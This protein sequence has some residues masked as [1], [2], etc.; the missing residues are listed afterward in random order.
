MSTEQARRLLGGYATGT[1]TPDETRALFEAA[2]E[3]Q[4]LF[5]ELNHEQVLRDLLDDGSARRDVL[6]ALSRAD[7]LG[8]PMRRWHGY[9]WALAA[10]AG[11]IVVVTALWVRPRPATHREA[12]SIAKLEAP[13]AAFPAPAAAVPP[14]PPPPMQAPPRVHTRAKKIE[15]REPLIAAAR[16]PVPIQTESQAIEVQAPAPAAAAPAVQPAN[17][18]M[19]LAAKPA[20]PQLSWTIL[21][22]DEAGNFTDALPSTVFHE[23]DQIRIRVRPRVNGSVSLLEGSGGETQVIAPSETAVAGAEYMLPA[24]GPI[25]VRAGMTLALR[26]TPA[27]EVADSLEARSVGKRKARPASAVTIPI[28]ITI[29]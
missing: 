11:V 7:A 5:N 9:R 25:A 17:L 24:T 26:F 3:D 4:D 27:G 6:A 28:H 19:A 29:E 18:G 23:G 10:A 2:L 1:L 20:F 15:P 22:R 16:P 13:G 21:R 12:A 8:R 14:A